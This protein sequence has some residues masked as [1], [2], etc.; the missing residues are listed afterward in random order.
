M[1]KYSYDEMGYLK[2]QFREN[3]MQLKN[4]FLEIAA[5]DNNIIEFVCVGIIFNCSYFY[6][7][8]TALNFNKAVQHISQMDFICTLYS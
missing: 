7:E 3:T 4:Y 5:I 1:I 6:K 2:E 8:H